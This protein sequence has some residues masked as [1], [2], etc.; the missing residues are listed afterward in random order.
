MP[1]EIVVSTSFRRDVRR[2]TRRGLDVD[3]LWQIIDM[4]ANGVSLPVNSRPHRVTGNWADC[5][6]CHVASDWLLVWI[7]TSDSV[8]LVR[9]GTH[10]D[11]FG[12]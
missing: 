11:I 12:R 5:W 4:L 6:D 7:E 3:R 2:A 9:T 10:A 8:R 1:R